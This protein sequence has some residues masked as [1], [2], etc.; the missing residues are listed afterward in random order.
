[1]M[2]V[3]GGPVERWAATFPRCLD[4][5]RPDSLHPSAEAVHVLRVGFCHHQLFVRIIKLFVDRE[6]R[7]GSWTC[8]SER[9][10]PHISVAPNITSETGPNLAAIRAAKVLHG[11]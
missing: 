9:S 11:V 10:S 5:R 7:G 2:L 6:G 4:N 1:M 3:V 8:S